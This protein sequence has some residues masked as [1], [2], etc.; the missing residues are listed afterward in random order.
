MLIFQDII[1]NDEFMSDI[2]PYTLEYD[3]VIMKVQSSFKPK[4]K[5]GEVDI[6]CGNEFGGGENQA[7]DDEPTENVNDVV[8]NANL[9]PV[10]MSK[11]E[12]M[13]YIKDFFKKVVTYLEEHDKK[14]RVETFKKGATAFIKFIVPHF[15]DLEL[16]TGSSHQE[17]EDVE[18]AIA[19]AYWEDES[20][21]GPV[22]YFFKDALKEEKC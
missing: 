16:Y 21:K 9:Q 13:A 10:T 19:I 3:D 5:V 12:F 8:Y 2:F 7:V 15:D 14:D 17:H 20:A 18:G 11:K 22:L 6:G 1:K 4:D